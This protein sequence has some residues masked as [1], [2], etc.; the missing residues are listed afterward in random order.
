MLS[1][2]VDEVILM[3]R[4]LL[5]V[6]SSPLQ[7]RMERVASCYSRTRLTGILMPLSTQINKQLALLLP[8]EK[9]TLGITILNMELQRCKIG[10]TALSN[11]TW[12]G[13]SW[14]EDFEEVS[15]TS[16][17][18]TLF[19]SV[20]EVNGFQAILAA[21]SL[22]TN[23][24]PSCRQ[25]SCIVGNVGTRSWQGNKMCNFFHKSDNVIVVQY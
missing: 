19:S 5:P 7:W 21:T 11:V 15:F 12:V 6:W 8:D 22:T 14:A 23:L 10:W 24:W 17:G 4:R 16:V 25:S 20:V 13:V 1:G 18:R 9:T 2:L 3:L